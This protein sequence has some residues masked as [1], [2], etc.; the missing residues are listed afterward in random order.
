MWAGIVDDELPQIHEK[1]E[2]LSSVDVFHLK[3][4]DWY[5]S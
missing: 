3:S 4:G 5:N 1:R 2:F